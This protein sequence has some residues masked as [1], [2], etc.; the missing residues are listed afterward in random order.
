M[1]WAHTHNQ[2]SAAAHPPRCS[3][4]VIIADMWQRI[5]FLLCFVCVDVSIAADAPSLKVG[6]KRFTES[7]VLA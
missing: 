5:L 4:N 1:A 7:Y 6:S 2:C 3:V